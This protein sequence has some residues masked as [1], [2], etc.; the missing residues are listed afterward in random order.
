MKVLALAGLLACASFAARVDIASI[1]LSVDVPSGWTLTQTSP[2]KWDLEDT[3]LVASGTSYAARHTGVVQFEATSGASA[4]GTHDWAI[5]DAY[6]W[7]VFLETNPCYGWVYRDDSTRVDGLFAMFVQGEWSTCPDT[8]GQGIAT[9][10]YSVYVRSVAQG[11]VGWEMSVITDT[12]DFQNNYFDYRDVLDSVQIDQTFQTIGVKGTAYRKHSNFRI[13]HANDAWKITPEPQSD[14][15]EMRVI[16]LQGRDVGRLEK[17]SND[18]SWYPGSADGP[19]WA[20]SGSGS[21]RIALRIP[22]LR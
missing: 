6:A 17:G 12:L 14:V 18:W 20:V 9:Q 11:D 21:S 4:V 16:D 5:E 15:S 1:G 7:R 13:H 22:V 2:L 3:V 8:T 19:V 10:Y